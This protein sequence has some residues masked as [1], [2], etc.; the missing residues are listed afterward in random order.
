ML[1]SSR[2]ISFPD[3]FPNMSLYRWLIC[4]WR[5]SIISPVL[6]SNTA[7]AISDNNFIRNFRESNYLGVAGVSVSSMHESMTSWVSVLCLA[8]V[9]FSGLLPS[10]FDT[11]YGFVCGSIR[12]KGRDVTTI[13]FSPTGSLFGSFSYGGEWYGGCVRVTLC[14]VAVSSITLCGDG[15]SFRQSL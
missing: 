2:P 1:W 10:L 13:S 15:S 6:T 3:D 14:G 12:G 5:Y 8:L 4:R 11:L 9:F 7:P